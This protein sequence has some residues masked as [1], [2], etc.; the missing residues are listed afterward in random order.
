MKYKVCIPERYMAAG[1]VE[2]PSP[3][4]CW[5]RVTVAYLSGVDE[6]ISQALGNG[7]DV[8]EGSLTGSSAQ[9]PDSLER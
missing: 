6:L 9:Q 8:P 5:V 4:T 1:H 2:Y 3:D 7:L